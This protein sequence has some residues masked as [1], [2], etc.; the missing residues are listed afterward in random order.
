MTSVQVRDI[1]VRFD[2][3]PVLQGV[4]LFVASGSWLGLIGPNGAGKSTML[5]SI[6]G[7]VPFEGEIALGDEPVGRLNRRKVARL[8]AFVPQTPFIPR[9]MTV[10]DYLLMGRTPYIPYLGTESR[11]DLE[12]VG[13]VLSELELDDL[14]DRP[15][16]SLS[17]GELQRV[18]LGRALAQQAPVL[19]LDEPT[20]ALDVGHQQQVLELVDSLRTAN[21]LTVISAMHDLT[22]AGQFADSLLLLDGGV[23]AASGSASEVLTEAA[24]TRHY[25]AHVRVIEDPDG[26]ILVVPTRSR[27]GVTSSYSTTSTDGG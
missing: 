13:E 12:V 11:T 4:S 10:T 22:L 24:I 18:V 26:G 14:G 9:S 17:G 20:S 16:G 25:G 21:N 1:S 5:R 15:I 8:V 2:S 7:L 19:L 3:V 6:A 27:Q 23:T